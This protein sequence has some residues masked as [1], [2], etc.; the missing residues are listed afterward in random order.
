MMQTRL[1]YLKDQ[2]DLKQY[3]S[4]VESSAYI[5][6]DPSNITD[7]IITRRLMRRSSVCLFEGADWDNMDMLAPY[8]LEMSVLS[9]EE[10]ERFFVALASGQALL[11]SS[12]QNIQELK[13]HLK[14]FTM[15][16][17]DQRKVI[18][19]KFY[20]A[21]NF[22]FYLET[23]PDFLKLFEAVDDVLCRTFDDLCQYAKIELEA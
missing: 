21:I 23:E 10:R 16:S 15:S 5:L 2:T 19:N 18:I 17:S 7:P 4:G 11:L 9:V 12:S 6:I 20:T 22:L 1:I 13:R 14:K 8:I 3:L